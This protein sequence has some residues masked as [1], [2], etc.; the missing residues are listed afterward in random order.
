M[1][2]GV[3]KPVRDETRSATCNTTR[4]LC[5]RS[6]PLQH[7]LCQAGKLASKRMGLWGYP[8]LLPPRLRGRHGRWGVQR[9]RA[10]P[11]DRLSKSPTKRLCRAHAT[12]AGALVAAIRVWGAA[13]SSAR[14][15]E[16]ASVCK[17]MIAPGP[18][19]P[20]KTHRGV[21]RLR[22][23]ASPSRLQRQHRQPA[24]HVAVKLLLSLVG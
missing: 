4:S 8:P 19:T 21:R 24:R 1:R 23:H 20:N 15:N 22:Q 11:G 3:A 5:K 14:R 13:F 18:H 6:W 2:E 9:Q 7:C 12:I 10:P 16:A 17:A